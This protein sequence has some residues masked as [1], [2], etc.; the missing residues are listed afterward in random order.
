VRS[1]GSIS[2]VD[3]VQIAIDGNRFAYRAKARGGDAATISDKSGSS[4][5]EL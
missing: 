4:F 2:G 1:S 3:W 5:G